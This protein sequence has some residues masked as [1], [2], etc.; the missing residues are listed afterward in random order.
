MC[1]GK[2]REMYAPRRY[3]MRTRGSGIHF[4]EFSIRTGSLEE[5]IIAECLTFLKYKSRLLR[6][7]CAV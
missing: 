5:F 4:C 6:A 7:Y 2:V 3:Y 1:V